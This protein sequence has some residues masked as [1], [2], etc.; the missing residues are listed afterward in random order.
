[1]YV[2]GL[3]YFLAYHVLMLTVMVWLPWL[4]RSQPL[5]PFE[6]PGTFSPLHWMCPHGHPTFDIT[7]QEGLGDQV[8]QISIQHLIRDYR[9]K[10]V[11]AFLILLQK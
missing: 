3:F 4:L 7:T 6:E 8:S 1:M 11:A 9:E 10:D 5:L 2:V